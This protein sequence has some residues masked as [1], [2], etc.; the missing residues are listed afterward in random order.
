[1]SALVGAVVLIQQCEGSKEVVKVPTM[2][3]HLTLVVGHCV[4]H[5]YFTYPAYGGNPAIVV[6]LPLLSGFNFIFI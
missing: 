6:S 5:T 4:G 3:T 1:M 2:G